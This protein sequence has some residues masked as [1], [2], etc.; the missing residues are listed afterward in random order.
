M[1]VIFLFFF[2]LIM[3]MP[4][5]LLSHD[6]KGKSNAVS[7][8]TGESTPLALVVARNHHSSYSP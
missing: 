7:V 6:Q 1:T 8:Y 2:I 4:S 5:L 3:H